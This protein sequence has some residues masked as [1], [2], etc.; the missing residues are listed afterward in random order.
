MIG[1]V[2]TISIEV[3]TALNIKDSIPTGTYNIVTNLSSTDF[4]QFIKNT[5]VPGFS[6]N[7][8]DFGSWFYNDIV[9]LPIKAGNL[10]NSHK[11]GLYTITYNLVDSFGNT[12]S[13]N[14]HGRLPY[15]DLSGGS[16]SIEA[17]KSKVKN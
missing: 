16:Y 14:Y 6:R 7:G 9:Y 13:G 2:D 4:N 17:L 1:P 3:N 11:N 5:L 12:I 15:V 10:I 8:N